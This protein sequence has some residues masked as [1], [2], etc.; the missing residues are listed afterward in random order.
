LQPNGDYEQFPIGTGQLQT[1]ASVKAKLQ[2][3][4]VESW[5]ESKPGSV[6]VHWRSLPAN[7]A[8]QD[9]EAIRQAF[10]DEVAQ[11]R[12]S[13]LSFD[14]GLEIRVSPYTNATA[15]RQTLDSG[16][17]SSVAAYLGDDEAD[18]DAFWALRDQDLGVLVRPRR[19]KTAAHL[20]IKPPEEVLKFLDAWIWACDNGPRPLA[21]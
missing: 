4:N 6:A 1:L 15:V 16:S 11:D 20:W 9:S 7:A 10:H 14:G 2:T 18:E 5:L 13:I 19:R 21:S 12:V 3:I 8:T 17:P